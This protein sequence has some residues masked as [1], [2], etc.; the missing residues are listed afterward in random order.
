MLKITDQLKEREAMYKRLIVFT[1]A[2]FMIVLYAGPLLGVLGRIFLILAPFFL[3]GILCLVY[4]SISKVFMNIA[5]KLFNVKNTSRA[6]AICRV[7]VII[8]CFLFVAGV[9]I[10]MIPSL[11]NSVTSIIQVLP[12][13]IQK[14]YAFALE[15][16]NGIPAMN[17]WLV[18]K[19]D[20]FQDTAAILGK[21]MN[22]LM[23]G[24]LGEALSGVSGVISS[25]FGSFWLIF[26]SIVFSLIAFFNVELVKS[27]GKMFARAF[28]SPK[29]YE[30]VKD[31]CKMVVNQFSL[32]LRGALTE[33]FI[34]GTLVTILCLI[35]G[36][37]NPVLI[38]VFIGIC[39][40][41]PMFGG[42]A[43]AII[44]TLFLFVE[45]PVKAISFI[46]LFM[47]IQQIEGNFIYPTV[48][49][50]SI[51]L[52]PIYVF[53]SI[54]IGSSTAGLL[55]MV[56]SI[57]VASVLYSLVKRQAESYMKHRKESGG[58]PDAAVPE[59]SEQSA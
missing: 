58:S 4:L 50:K 15:K 31:V 9:I 53:V 43:G 8:V 20:L 27:E 45:S 1:L 40:L 34:L 46:I 48:V 7:I 30:Q 13:Y 33:C 47:C 42:L 37:S 35:L 52:P 44:C 57:P 26:M 49:G 22:L 28:L 29:R 24:G 2:I 16:T 5:S 56:L 55:G 39:A 17:Q 38:G 11:I 25:T 51:G 59:P 54:V 19:Q 3:G 14:I 23:T 41:V 21:G 32:Y 36:V 12:G 18:E 10:Y 6:N